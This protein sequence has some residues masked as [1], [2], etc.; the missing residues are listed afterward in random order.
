MS[1]AGTGSPGT[2]PGAGATGWVAPAFTAAAR[3]TPAS[4][5]GAPPGTA[6]EVTGTAAGDATG[7]AVGAA[8]GVGATTAGVTDWAVGIT[9]G[10]GWA[11]GTGAAAAG[12]N[13]L[14]TVLT[15]PG[16]EGGS[17]IW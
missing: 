11:D 10:T 9:G 7:T 13:P 3:A 16:A 2:V 1:N 17:G 4:L 15:A 6:L 14:C 12:S 5:L 8:D